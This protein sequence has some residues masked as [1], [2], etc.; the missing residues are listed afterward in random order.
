MS[1]K[2]T[3]ASGFQIGGVP[4]AG[5]TT[6]YV[7]VLADMTKQQ[8]VTDNEGNVTH[9][10]IFTQAKVTLLGG[11]FDAAIQVDY[12]YKNYWLVYDVNVTD[13]NAQYL[14]IEEDLKA[15]LIVDNPTWDGKISIVS[16]GTGQAE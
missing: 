14:E 1:L 8:P 9:I 7:R 15:K 12:I 5:I 10:E 16:L 2:I 13:M 3:D 11:L 4:N 6:I